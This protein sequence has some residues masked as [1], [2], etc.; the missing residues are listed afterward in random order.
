MKF[1]LYATLFQRPYYGA[2]LDECIPMIAKSC[3]T[4]DGVT[5]NI[6][7]FDNIYDSKGNHITA[8]DVIYSYEQSISLAQF[9]NAA[10]DMEPLEKVDDYNIILTLT[11]TTPGVIESL[12]TNQQLYIVSKEWYENASDEE[13]TT[14][15]ATTA[16]YKVKSFS[17]GAGAVLEAV[18][19]YWQTDEQYLPNTVTRNVKEIEFRVMTEA[20]MRVIAL[21][22]KEVDLAGINASDLAD[23]YDVSSGT[24][25]DG[26]NVGITDSTY[27]YA[28]FCNMDSGK[29]VLADNLELRKAVFYALDSEQLML[30]SGNSEATARALKSFGDSS[31]GGYQDKWD[32]EDYYGY[33]L[34][35]AKECLENAGYKSG[36]VTLTILASSALWNDSTM[37]VIIA[38]LNDAGINVNPLT[39]EQALFNTYKDDSTQWDLMLDLKGCTTGHIA[40]LWSICFDPSSYS[41]GSVCFTHDDELTALL[42]DVLNVTDDASIDAFHYYLKDN[43]ICMGLYTPKTIY[44]AQDGI[45]EYAWYNG[46]Q[47][48]SGA[49]TFSEDYESAINY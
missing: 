1:E 46:T 48:V 38:E 5:Y 6:E 45:L 37:S 42:D 29:S 22:N 41:N 9:R 8:D 24:S 36:E 43:A 28:I 15:P 47:P 26:W 12:L 11:N 16:G 10:S 14:D 17:S 13:K 19:D 40:S 44:V 27:T 2:P 39:C 4:E 23:F 33:D 32:D 35:K 49:L 20:S 30:A 21:E 25:L 18:E 31:Y 7:L 34:D 3:T